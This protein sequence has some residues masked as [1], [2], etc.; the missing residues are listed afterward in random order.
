MKRKHLAI[1]SNTARLLGTLLVLMV[2]LS[3]PPSAVPRPS[4][5]PVGPQTPAPNPTAP[6][7]S[8]PPQYPELAASGIES[9]V[10]VSLAPAPPLPEKIPATLLSDTPIQPSPLPSGVRDLPYVP[11]SPDT[12]PEFEIG[13]LAV[14]AG[15]AAP[16][17]AAPGLVLA[18]MPAPIKTFDAQDFNT[19]GNGHPP[20]TNGDVGPTYFMQAVN[21]SIG[22]FNKQTGALVTAFT[23]NS[24][25]SLAGTGTACDTANF[26]DPVVLYDSPNGHWIFMDFAWTDI[27]NGPYFFC[28]GVSQSADPTGAYWR[29]A[30]RADDALHPY[31]PDYPKGGVWPDGLYFSANMFDCL[32]STCSSATYKDARAYVFNLLKM[33]AGSPL[34]PADVQA[35]DTSSSYFT[36]LP[37]NVRG[38]PPPA[39]TPNYFVG[40][41]QVGFFWDVFKFHV[42]FANPLNTSLTAPVQVS[43]AA[44]TPRRFSGPRAFSGQ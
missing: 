15:S 9:D 28:F 17:P 29:Y 36:L 13:P 43:Q 6:L 4:S 26:G 5:A 19:N 21:T 3:F 30:I 44:Y 32:N 27:M 1:L 14:K 7:P 40:E 11:P 35:A 16:S 10:T 34:L 42:D 37:S 18:P 25:W 12:K 8:K 22:I 41:D 38:S 23:F 39:D 31:L 24:F 20:D 33:E 2:L